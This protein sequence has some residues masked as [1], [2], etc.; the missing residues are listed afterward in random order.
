VTGRK[1]KAD[2]WYTQRVEGRVRA[3]LM[4]RRTG[5]KTTMTKETMNNDKKEPSKEDD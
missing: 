1:I 2:P 5:V 3:N 4:G